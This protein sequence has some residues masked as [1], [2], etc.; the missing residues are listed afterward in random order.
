MT[1][2]ALFFYLLAAAALLGAVG[3]VAFRQPI[4]GA[5]SLLVTLLSVAGLFLLRGAEFL[6]AAQIV[7]YAGG[8]LALF[9]FAIMFVSYREEEKRR[10]WHPQWPAA[11]LLGI[12]LAA[13]LGAFLFRPA[14][15]APAGV[16]AV[17]APFGGNTE[18]LSEVLFKTYL[19]PFEVIS[20]FLLVA[21][22]GGILMASWGVKK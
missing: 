7:I 13:M 11:A 20:L 22:V 14:A 9:L 12:G 8:I 15:G 4:H 5:V 19:V 1:L 18:A 10:K 16:G 2:T 3:V 6:A 21:M 17:Q